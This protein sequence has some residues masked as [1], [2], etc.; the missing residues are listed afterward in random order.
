MKTVG[1]NL[2]KKSGRVLSLIASLILLAGIFALYSCAKEKLTVDVPLNALVIE[3]DDI[4][5]EAPEIDDAE[6]TEGLE[7]ASFLRSGDDGLNEFSATR[8]FTLEDFEELAKDIMQYQSRIEDVKVG[9]V[10]INITTADDV[11]T[12]LK[13]VV[14]KVDN[15]NLLSIAEYNLGENYDVPSDLD[16]QAFSQQLLLKLLLKGS[17]NAAISGKTDV[18]AGEKLTV[19]IK[20]DDITL[21]AK[22]LDEE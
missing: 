6:N 22:L 3:W 8:V 13:D 17:F 15:T 9:S 16:L 1:M 2:E 4:L 5:V 18:E 7:T 19:K 10:I 14:L 12:V 11:G 21:V 20:M